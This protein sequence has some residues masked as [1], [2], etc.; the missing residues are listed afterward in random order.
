MNNSIVW[1]HWYYKH[2]VTQTFSKRFTLKIHPRH[3]LY[4]PYPP[5]PWNC[6]YPNHVTPSP[7]PK[8]PH[9]SMNRAIQHP[10]ELPVTS[11]L[12]TPLFFS[13]YMTKHNAPQH[14]PQP[15][16][17]QCSNPIRPIENA[18]VPKN[19][20]C[21]VYRLRTGPYSKYSVSYEFILIYHPVSHRIY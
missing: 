14:N 18:P 17:T 20:L 11:C 3:V 5:L 16:N 19:I 10:S 15:L 6:P 21:S 4:R 9:C 2:H 12:S 7:H 1:K 8:W 13:I